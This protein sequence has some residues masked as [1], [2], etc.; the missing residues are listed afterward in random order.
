[1]QG[2]QKQLRAKAH[3]SRLC[4]FRILAERYH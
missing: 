1:M 4:A 3:R 2:N